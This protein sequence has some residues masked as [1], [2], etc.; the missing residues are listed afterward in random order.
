VAALR[1]RGSSRD[2]EERDVFAV[3]A[4][5]PR[6]VLTTPAADPRSQREQHP[7]PWLLELD[8]V[9]VAL[10]SFE[11]WLGEGRAPA[12]PTERDVAELLAAHRAGAALDALPAI[13]ANGI[14]RGLAVARSRATGGFDEWAGHVGAHPL[15]SGELAEHRSPTGLESWATCPFRYFLDKV[16]GVRSLD[17]PGTV[18]TITG[19]DRG[20]LVH[21]VLERFITAR[22]DVDPT[23][24]W[25]ADARSELAAIADEVEDTYRG[26]GRTGRQLLWDPEWRNLQ[27]HLAAIIDHGTVAPELAGLVPIAVEHGFGF[28]GDSKPAVEVRVGDGP[29]LR[30]GG[31]IDRVDASPDRKRVVVVDYKTTP[32]TDYRRMAEDPVDRGRRMQLPIYALAAREL[33]PEAESVAAYYWFVHPRASIELRGLEFDDDTEQRFREVLGTVVGGIEQGLFPAR[34]GDDTWLPGVGETY[35]ACRWC[36]YN[37]V[38]PTG[39][40]DRWER[41]RVH[42]SLARYADLAEGHLDA[43]EEGDDA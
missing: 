12:T 7:A 24:A 5:A 35:D 11:A 10:P 32:G 1:P 18:E 36:D 20:S 30:F 23:R 22:L 14:G 26:H 38:C 33:V 9:H 19:R 27:R 40:A 42:G 8:G 43:D 39:R 6:R 21:E 29:P 34:P 13:T 31:R 4:A 3:L 28:E 15:L 17:D 25:D 37:R 16:L 2:E 41:V